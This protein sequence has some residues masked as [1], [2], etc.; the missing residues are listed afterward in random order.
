MPL[1]LSGCFQS[2]SLMGPAITTASTGNIYQAGLSYGFNSAVEITT[3]KTPINHAIDILVEEKSTL[4]TNQKLESE[5][6]HEP[7][8]FKTK[9]KLIA[10]I[11]FNI[12][13]TRGKLDLRN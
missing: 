13:K 7:N 8:N 5:I 1:I 11:K 12:E 10:L 3:G 6:Y 9:D 2:T 4:S